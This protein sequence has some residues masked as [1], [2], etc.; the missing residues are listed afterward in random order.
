MRSTIIFKIFIC[1]NVILF[2]ACAKET[3][4]TQTMYSS[5]E[6]KKVEPETQPNPV[7]QKAEPTSSMCPDN[8]KIL[9]S[10]SKFVKIDHAMS[11]FEE[12]RKIAVNWCE[13]FN[14]SSDFSTQ[15]CDKCCE[16]NFQCR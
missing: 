8:P 12:A 13:Q 9:R 4:K 5:S 1:I 3:V 15:K 14:L 11:Q 2:T 10:T 7:I 6:I 16:S